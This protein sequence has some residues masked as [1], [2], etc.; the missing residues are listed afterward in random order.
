MSF[1]WFFNNIYDINL[2]VH[3]KKNLITNINRINFSNK[4]KKGKKFSFKN[5]NKEFFF[6]SSF[7]FFY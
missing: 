4:I 7:P 1:K 5:W 2:H 6:F 3:K